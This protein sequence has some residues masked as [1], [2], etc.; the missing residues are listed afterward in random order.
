MKQLD[1][2]FSEQQTSVQNEVSR[3]MVI[4]N[5]VRLK[6]HVYSPDPVVRAITGLVKFSIHRELRVRLQ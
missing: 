4:G 1:T 6:V 2:V 3:N 5:Q